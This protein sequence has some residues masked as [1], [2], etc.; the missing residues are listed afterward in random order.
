MQR[1]EAEERADQN[2]PAQDTTA[3]RPPRVP[4][5]QKLLGT[6]DCELVPKVWRFEMA[7][8]P[9]DQVW[10]V[11]ICQEQFR[12]QDSLQPRLDCTTAET[13]LT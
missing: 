13:T 10:E 8:A 2:K 12:E 5:R 9:A 7:L 4:V 11:Q 6:Q 1:S 3:R